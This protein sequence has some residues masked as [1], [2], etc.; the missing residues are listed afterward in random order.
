MG[1][2]MVMALDYGTKSDNDY[3]NRNTIVMSE[4]Y[5]VLKTHS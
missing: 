3:H 4:Y 1:T 5:D 2:V